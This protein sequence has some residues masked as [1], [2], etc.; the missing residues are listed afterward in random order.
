MGMYEKKVKVGDLD[1]ISIPFTYNCGSKTNISGVFVLPRERSIGYYFKDDDSFV[2]FFDN[3]EKS[4]DG[5]PVVKTLINCK[6]ET[7]Y[8]FEEDHGYRVYRGTSSRVENIE[9][10]ASEYSLYLDNSKV[11]DHYFKI[12]AVYTA[13]A[14]PM[15]DHDYVSSFLTF[16]QYVWNKIIESKPLSIFLVILQQYVIVRLIV[17]PS[18]VHVFWMIPEFILG[19]ASLVMYTLTSLELLYLETPLRMKALG[20][21]VYYTAHGVGGLL[22]KLDKYFPPMPRVSEM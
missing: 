18:R 4:N 14:K 10:P 7:P 8:R 16:M 2:R 15:P 11:Y 12:G 22:S 19:S 20:M 1:E 13:L 9:L 5:D 17:V 6:N 3:V 21:A